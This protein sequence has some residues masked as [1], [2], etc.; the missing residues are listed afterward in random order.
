MK[1]ERSETDNFGHLTSEEE[2]WAFWNLTASEF[3]DVY[4]SSEDNG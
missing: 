3:L 4:L 1:V 2:D